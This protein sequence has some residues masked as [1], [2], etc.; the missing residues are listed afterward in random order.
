MIKADSK[1]KQVSLPK[2]LI[3]RVDDIFEERGFSSRAEYVR[4]AL[5]KQVDQDEE[6]IRNR[7]HG[8]DE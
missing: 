3:A 2:P 1:W 6:L 7:K 8:G 5:I 4:I